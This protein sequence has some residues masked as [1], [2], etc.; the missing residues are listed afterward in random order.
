MKI[1]CKNCGAEVIPAVDS[2]TGREV[3]AVKLSDGRYIDHDESC[4]KIRARKM[5]QEE[6]LKIP[7]VNLD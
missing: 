3:D 7:V 6:L 1:I 5:K 2:I 4:D